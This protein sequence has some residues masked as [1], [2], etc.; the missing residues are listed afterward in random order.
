[1]IQQVGLCG[2]AVTSEEATEYPLGRAY[3]TT[4]FHGMALNREN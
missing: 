2:P 4:I 1:M 3:E